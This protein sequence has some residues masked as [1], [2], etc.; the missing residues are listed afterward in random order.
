LPD[1]PLGEQLQMFL[2]LVVELAVA[3]VPAQK[4]AQ[5][6]RKSPQPRFSLCAHDSLA[7]S[8]RSTRPI[9]PEIRSQFSASTSSCFSPRLV[10]E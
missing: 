5:L 1:K 2:D 6:R 3:M 9:T 10:M 7:A 4:T 8:S